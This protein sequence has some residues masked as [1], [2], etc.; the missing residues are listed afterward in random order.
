MKLESSAHE[1][2]N[3]AFPITPRGYDALAVDEFLDKILRDY[4]K[5]ES[6]CLISKQDMENKDK[7]IKDLEKKVDD[8]TIEIKK[9]EKRFQGITEKDNVSIDNIELVKRIRALEKYLYRIGVNPDTI[10]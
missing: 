6:N 3:N 2:L 4:R 9:F 10:K 5:I 7:H 1:I 8:L